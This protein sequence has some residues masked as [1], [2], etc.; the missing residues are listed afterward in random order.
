MNEI[1]KYIFE[2][3]DKL[4][5]YKNSIPKSIVIFGIQNHLILDLYQQVEPYFNKIKQELLNERE[6][7][8][9]NLFESECKYEIDK[10]D[11]LI[12]RYLGTDRI[13]YVYELQQQSFDLQ[14]NY[15]ENYD[16]DLKKI[17]DRMDLVIFDVYEYHNK[18]K[19]KSYLTDT[20]DFSGLWVYEETK[21]KYLFNQLSDDEKEYVELHEYDIKHSCP[22]YVFIHN[23]YDNEKTEWNLMNLMRSIFKWDHLKWSIICIEPN[24]EYWGKD[25]PDDL[26]FEVLYNRKV[27]DLAEK[28]SPI[29]NRLKTELDFAGIQYE[30]QYPIGKYILDFYIQ[31]GSIKLNV[32]CDG[33]E[34][35]SDYTA[36]EYDSERDKFMQSKGFKV[37]RLHGVTIWNNPKFCVEK[38]LKHLND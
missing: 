3:I 23:F 15:I 24:F 18:L 17:T 19:R 29:E 35:H 32:E 38:I 26:K 5:D 36:K 13:D 33:K 25:K 37:I 30:F 8:K 22:N 10:Y 14:R 31:K 11:E 34:F 21:D 7:E 28:I 12:N 6:I 27:F 4:L 9:Q 16:T 2:Q 20:L 1:T